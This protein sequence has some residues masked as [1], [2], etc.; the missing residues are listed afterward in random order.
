M[1]GITDG[2]RAAVAGMAI[3]FP[4]RSVTVLVPGQSAVA[5]FR[6]TDTYG[7][8]LDL[9]G[10]QAGAQTAQVIVSVASFTAP[11]IGDT[12]LVDGEKV[13]VTG[14][15][16]DDAAVTIQYRTQHAQ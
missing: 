10:S 8:T 16:D 3:A 12:I 11:D 14:V 15:E 7:D 5:G 4:E 1:A 13:S 6:S 9:S 2:I